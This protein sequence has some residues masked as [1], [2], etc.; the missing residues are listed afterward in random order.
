MYAEVSSSVPHFLQEGLS[1]IPITCRCLLRVLSPVSRPITA[2]VCVLLKDSSQAPVAR[3]GP[4]IN[5]R[6]CLCTTRTLPQSSVLSY[7]SCSA[8]KP[9]NRA[10]AQNTADQNRSLR[11]FQQIYS[12][13][14]RHDQGPNIANFPYRK[15]CCVLY[16]SQKNI[17]FS[18]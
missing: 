13:S 5:S 14:L 18:Q 3:S 15:H 9:L 2:L 12:L 1:L 16:H 17:E 6:A 10:Q 7:F 8:W 4:E 11:A